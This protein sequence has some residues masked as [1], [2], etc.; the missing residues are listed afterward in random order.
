MHEVITFS[1][2][3]SAGHLLTQLYNVQES[4]LAYSKDK[5]LTHANDVFLSPTKVRSRTNYYPRTVNVEFCGGYGFLGKYE[6]HE[7]AKDVDLLAE[8]YGSEVIRKEPVA[9]KN[10]YQKRLDLGSKPDGSMLNVSNT[11]YWTAYNKLIY[12]P[13]SLLELLA[14]QHPEGTNKNFPRLKFEEYQVGEREYKHAR[15]N[16]D[17]T[18]R[19]SLEAL[20]NIQGVNFVSELD[21]AWGGFTNEL[22]LDVKD[23]YFNNG[24]HS[25]YCLW[26]YGLLAHREGARNTLNAL[27]EIKSFVGF[28]RSSTLF[29]PLNVPLSCLG[30]LNSSYDV[31]SSWHRGA[32]Q[33]LLV[34]SIWGL[35]CQ[36]DLPVRMAAIEDKLL[37]GF[38]NRT[39]VNEIDLLA[40]KKDD[41]KK[42]DV[43]G[44]V[45]DVNI[46]D[47]YQNGPNPS[48][49]ASDNKLQLGVS[50][51]ASSQSLSS[52]IID[53]SGSPSATYAN[54]YLQE[55]LFLDTFPDIFETEPNSLSF[56]TT[57]KQST[58]I[59]EKLKQYRKTVSRL[60]HP[61]HLDI[62]G[63][64]G[65]LVEEISSLIEEY[66]VC[67][68]DE[69]DS[70]S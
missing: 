49:S 23:E 42:T 16:V 27:T 45:R 62:I 67:Y 66:T 1:N 9:Q 14:F 32:L 35:N 31:L 18:F 44:L 41:A 36:L 68:S 58:A 65:E 69:S 17:D 64:K 29:I 39:I 15:N 52:V 2:S 54:N 10:E 37:R 24:A 28:A 7:A 59:R 22:M 50:E 11:K 63:D 4:H 40:K 61:Q 53:V 8:T 33:S 6:Y 30:I 51:S 56:A 26:T 25:K 20:D 21:N 13:L 57:L 55:P 34:N 43:F 38:N 47:Y 70:E 12:R 19:K 5:K 3:N 46:M 60:R 48:A